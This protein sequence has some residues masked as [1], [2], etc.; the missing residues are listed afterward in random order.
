MPTYEIDDLISKP[1]RA[2]ILSDL[3]ATAEELGF[4]VIAWQPFSR[5]RGILDMFAAAFAGYSAVSAEIAKSGFMTLVA[6]PEGQPNSQWADIA[7]K[8]LYNIK[9]IP[10]GV[11]TCTEQ[12]TNATAATHGPFDPGELHFAHVLTGKTYHNKEVVLTVPP[13]VSS[14]TI[15]AD[16]L[17]SIS[18]AAPGTITIFSTPLSG[19]EVTNIS[20]AVGQDEESDKQLSK[21]GINKLSSLSPNGAGGIYSYVATSLETLSSRIT[22]VKEIT[23]EDT[24]EINV[25]VANASGPVDPADVDLV[26]EAIQLVAVPKGT[27][28][29]TNSA[30]GL[31]VTVTATVYLSRSSTTTV[32]AYEI[33][34][35]KAMIGYFA[36][37]PIGGEEIVE[38]DG[39]IFEDAIKGVLYGITPEVVNVDLNAPLADVD[40][41]PFEVAK[42]LS[43]NL[44]VI[45]LS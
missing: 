33:A 17:G 30:T 36:Q 7:A 5:I 8:L 16:E 6:A 35:G 29:D 2:E 9:R 40:V 1:T 41:G 31:N 43:F 28:A 23:D 26:D 45:K 42:L 3:L 27:T 37:L 20:A 24:G 21:R 18:N 13:G 44:T 25:I 34:A 4:P 19:V 32:S 15:E 22:R 39:K 14:F 11:A 10:A 12:L 38:G